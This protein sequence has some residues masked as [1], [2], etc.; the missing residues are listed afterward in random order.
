VLAGNDSP[1]GEFHKIDNFKTH[2]ARVGISGYQ[3]FKFPPEKAKYLKVRL[4]APH[5]PNDPR[6]YLYEFRLFGRSAD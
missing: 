4:I 3:E 5:S 1:R 2:N 6:I